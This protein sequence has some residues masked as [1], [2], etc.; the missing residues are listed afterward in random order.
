MTAKLPRVPDR[1]CDPEGRPLFGAY[2]GVI[3][4]G[5]LAGLD[6][7][8]GRHGLTRLASEKCWQFAGITSPD[9]I[10]SLAIVRMGYAGVCFFSLFDREAS[11]F[12]V[13]QTSLAPP[14][15]AARIEDRP[16]DGARASFRIPGIHASILKPPG[17]GRYEVR[18]RYSSGDEVFDL[19]AQL[20]AADHPQGGPDGLSAVC[21]VA[22]KGSV[23]LTV[24]QVALPASGRMLLG[25][26]TI[27]LDQDAYGLLDYSHGYL[28]RT[29]AWM[30]ACGGGRLKRDRVVGLNLVAGFNDSLENAVWLGRDLIPVGPVVFHRDTSGPGAPWTI[31]D[32]E[33][34]LDL[35]FTPEGIRHEQRDIGPLSSHYLQPVGS[36]SGKLTDRRGREVWLTDLPGV[37]EEHFSRW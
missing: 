29:T 16:G 4:D 12:L 23:N 31:R 1:I 3:Q 25:E 33:G 20:R 19:A 35:T 32:E 8:H 6:I 28:D 18:L 24:K 14:L 7:E 26:R 34:K 22:G 11:E 15:V 36:F 27:E 13:D 17:L 10:V 30:W 21:P 9:W 2:R 5:S 37:C